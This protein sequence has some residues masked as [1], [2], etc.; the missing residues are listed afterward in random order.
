MELSM[1]LK[2]R[3]FKIAIVSIAF[4]IFCLGTAVGV[5]WASHYGSGETRLINTTPVM[6][7]PDNAT[8][9]KN[10]SMA[11]GPVNEEIEGLFVLDHVNGDL[12]CTAISARWGK[13]VMLYK[14]NVFKDLGVTKEGGADFVMTT[15]RII[16]R[17]RSSKL[18]PAACIVYVG[19]S[20]SGKVVGYTFSYNGANYQK[21]VPQ[22][23]ILNPIFAG[24]TRGA[25]LDREQ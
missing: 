1:S 9:G 25:E 21:G 17:Q 13:T 8:R 15:G 14:T 18:V 10:L 6:F 24:K 16:V 11:T 22:T 12:N 3:S 19:D 20:N 23:G 7:T 5:L 4:G 2:N